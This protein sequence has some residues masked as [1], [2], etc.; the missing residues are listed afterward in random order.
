M[1]IEKTWCPPHLC[2]ETGCGCA[3]CGEH[4]S[5]SGNQYLATTFCRNLV[6]H[7]T[8]VLHLL[9]SNQTPYFPMLDSSCLI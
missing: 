7:N 9:P 4:D 6:S 1:D 5:V 2:I 3:A 8:P